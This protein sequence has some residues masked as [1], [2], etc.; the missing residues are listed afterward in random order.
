[1]AQAPA[2][3]L[4]VIPIGIAAHAP[5]P[6]G[7]SDLAAGLTLGL[8]V[9]GAGLA[10]AQLARFKADPSHRGQVCDRGLWRYSRHP[11]YVFEWLGWCAFPIG[12]LGHGLGSPWFLASLLAPLLMYLLLRHVS[13]VPPLEASMR[14]SRGE[15]YLAYQARTPI[16]FPIPF[17]RSS[18]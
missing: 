4:L 2:G 10:D 9:V 5:G 8:A 15:A 3:T 18:Q 17:K 16:F 7:W 13:G 12:A 6:L 1:M 11:N 14:R